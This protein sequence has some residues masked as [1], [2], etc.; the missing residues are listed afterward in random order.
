MNTTHILFVHGGGEDGYGTDSK[1]A[2]SLREHL[3][4]KY[5]VT[6]PR[7]PA[8]DSDSA[9]VW[10]KKIRE[11]ITARSPS[12]L[13]GHSFGASNLLQY[14]V[15]YGTP[16]TI[17]A[18]F[19]LAPP[20]WGSDSDWDYEEYALP[21]HFADKISRTIPLF[22]YQCRD[23]EVVDVAHLDRYA[24]AMPWATVRKLDHGGHQMGNDL[25][26]VAKD[27]KAINARPKRRHTRDK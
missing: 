25:S 24:R 16:E 13:V 4:E 1:L 2:D 17:Q 19:L 14:L 23:D 12:F 3:G 18:V 10:P 8:P 27:I 22:L 21:Q 9:D 20:F 7:M 6:F 15:R 5:E 11:A 26:V